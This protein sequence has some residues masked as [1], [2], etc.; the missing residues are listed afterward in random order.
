MYV[1]FCQ[2]LHT[3]K[4]FAFH[5]RCSWEKTAN[6]KVNQ[7]V[8]PL[9]RSLSGYCVME[10]FKELRRAVLWTKKYTGLKLELSRAR[11]DFLLHFPKM[12][13][14][15][16]CTRNCARGYETKKRASLFFVPERGTK[17]NCNLKWIFRWF[18]RGMTCFRNM[19][20]GD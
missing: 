8:F 6:Y 18:R 20:A 11:M 3:G 14:F 19:N 17:K 4:C 7:W 5:I 2:I 9:S 13:R 16:L 1:I 15:P 10:T 12:Y